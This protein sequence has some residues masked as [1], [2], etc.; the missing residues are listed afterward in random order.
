MLFLSFKHM[1][2]CGTRIVIHSSLVRCSSCHQ[3]KRTHIRFRFIYIYVYIYFFF[4]V[5]CWQFCFNS[6]S[7]F[8]VAASEWSVVNSLAF[9]HGL[10]F[11]LG[12]TCETRPK[13][14]QPSQFSWPVR[15][16]AEQHNKW[17]AT[18][19]CRK[20]FANVAIKL[21]AKQKQRQNW[22]KNECKKPWK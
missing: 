11:G 9:G 3:E 2:Y 19:P 6:C 12:L 7:C 17:S 15:P 22:R 4:L 14:S 18:L 10:G 21:K 20:L 13:E 16:G 5:F 8:A 1:F